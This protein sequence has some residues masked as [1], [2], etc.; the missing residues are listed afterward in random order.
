MGARVDDLANFQ[1]LIDV[2]LWRL[3]LLEYHVAFLE[4]SVSSISFV[5][6]FGMTGLFGTL[7]VCAIYQELVDFRLEAVQEQYLLRLLLQLFAWMGQDRDCVVIAL[8][9]DDDLLLRR[10]ALLLRRCQ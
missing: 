5:L 1:E 9:L 7:E 8:V 4:L 10:L 6:L 3:C 2:S